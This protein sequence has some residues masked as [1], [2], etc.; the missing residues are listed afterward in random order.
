M[1]LKLF[2]LKK[3]GWSFR[4]LS[5]EYGVER[6]S[7]T[8]QFAKQR[9]IWRAIEPRQRRKVIAQLGAIGWSPQEIIEE[10]NVSQRTVY[11]Y[12]SASEEGMAAEALPDELVKIDLTGGGQ[13]P[14]R[15]AATGRPSLLP[16]RKCLDPS[17]ARAKAKLAQLVAE[18]AR[19][20]ELQAD[21][22]LATVSEARA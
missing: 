21:A 9:K 17:P 7:I 1:V 2:L 22:D 18:P 19:H 11:R 20:I 15:T 8:R 10:L 6:P 14:P 16:S 5:R 13:K 3:R 4:R 12:L